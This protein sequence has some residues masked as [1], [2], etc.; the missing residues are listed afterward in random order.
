MFPLKSWKSDGESPLYNEGVDKSLRNYLIP[1]AD[2]I[3][4]KAILFYLFLLDFFLNFGN[5]NE[6]LTW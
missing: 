1:Q 6:K 5:L 2:S 4:I 3:W